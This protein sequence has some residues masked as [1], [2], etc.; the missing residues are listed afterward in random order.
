MT[1]GGG[2]TPALSIIIQTTCKNS[3]SAFKSSPRANQHNIRLGVAHTVC[4]FEEH[5]GHRDKLRCTSTQC[6]LLFQICHVPLLLT[7][8][9]SRRQK[10]WLKLPLATLPLVS[11]LIISGM[12][13]NLPPQMTQALFRRGCRERHLFADYSSTF[14]R[15][16]HS[17]ISV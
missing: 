4:V 10:A 2:G 8:R 7:L 11:I 15:Y 3:P 5:G 6:P 14:S 17:V 12:K 9:R 16:E 1:W 13:M